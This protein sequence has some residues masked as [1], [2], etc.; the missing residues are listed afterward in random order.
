MESEVE[1]ES[2]Y[3]LIFLYIKDTGKTTKQMEEEDLFTLME[4]CMK[5]SGKTIKHMG[6]VFI[7]I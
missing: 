3:G 1:K 4:M 6:K 2:K 7:G 5:E